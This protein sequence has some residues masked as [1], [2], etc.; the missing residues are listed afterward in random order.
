VQA[1]DRESDMRAC[2]RTIGAALAG[3]AIALPAVAQYPVRPV[4]IVV[5]FPPGSTPDLVSR[6]VAERM[7]DDL[8][9][10]VI[11]ENRPGAGSTIA[12]E[13][14]ARSPADGYTL[15][16]SGC[17]GDGIVYGFV[18]TGRPPFDPFRD[19]TPVGRVMRD[20]W[21]LAVSPAL[22]I[23]SVDELVA[24]GKSKPGS[25]TFP[26]PGTG[27]SQHLQA[28]RFRMRVGLDATHVPYKDSPF[29]DLVAGRV[30]Y[31]VQSSA[32]VVPLIKSGKLKGLAVLST[33]RLASLPDVP[34]AAEAGLPDL[35]YNA[36]VCL[37][38]PG[39]TTRDVVARLNGALNKAEASDAVKQRFADLGVEAV[40]GSPEDTAKFI[41][42]L[43]TLV[44][45]LRTAVFGKAR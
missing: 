42:E 22:G 27:T 31:A 30:T 40:Q 15:I 16:V 23:G 39:G 20:H 24:L 38:A 17:S 43:M 6:A 12:T 37:Y 21:V 3:L 44:D 1:K 19:F 9:Q 11:V 34:T 45:Q 26:S 2:F 13:A 14:V 33:S 5:G 7:A 4:K 28:E 32:A 8:G 41:T 36:G 35:I 18:M 29:P 25:L 10:A